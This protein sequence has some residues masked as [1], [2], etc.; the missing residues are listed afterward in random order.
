MATLAEKIEMESAKLV[1][2]TKKRNDHDKKNQKGRSEFGE[3]QA[4]PE[5]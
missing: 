2:L 3:V 5:Q 1:T 4:N